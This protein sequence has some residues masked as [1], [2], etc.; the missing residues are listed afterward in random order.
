[1]PLQ[2][3]AAVVM[4]LLLN[5]GVDWNELVETEEDTAGVHGDNTLPT[6][7]GRG[8]NSKRARSQSSNRTE[9]R[10]PAKRGGGV[11]GGHGSLDRPGSS[12]Q[13]T[14]ENP[15]N[16][17]DCKDKSQVWACPL[18]ECRGHINY[19]WQTQCF[20]CKT[21]FHKSQGGNWT[22]SPK[23]EGQSGG[24][25]SSSHRGR[26]GDSVGRASRG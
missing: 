19:N 25:G 24:G 10:V 2:P 22:P 20:G 1:M 9:E 12:R 18:R 23:S 21:Y 11:R 8:G 15:P 3:K 5:V 17:R 7:G 4:P 13:V 6:T 26:R 16:P 14:V